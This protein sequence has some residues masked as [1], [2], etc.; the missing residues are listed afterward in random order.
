MVIRDPQDIWDF[1]SQISIPRLFGSAGHTKVRQLIKE[2]FQ[3]YQQSPQVVFE[4]QAFS[5][6]EGHMW[7]I[8]LYCFIVGFIILLPIWFY[9]HQMYWSGFLLT[10]TL[11]SS[12]IGLDRMFR[13]F[14]KHHIGEKKQVSG[15]NLWLRFE[16]TQPNAQKTLVIIAHYDSIS[17]RFPQITVVL[18]L[19]F[20]ELGGILFLL[21]NLIFS[22]LGILGW[23]APSAGNQFYWGIIVSISLWM[24]AFD[25]TTNR[26]S[27][28]LDNASG[29][30]ALD[31]LAQRLV[32]KPLETWRVLLLASD[33]EELGNR[34]AEAFAR[35]FTTRYPPEST[36]FL[37]VDTI[38][39]G[40]HNQDMI[41]VGSQRPKKQFS[42]YLEQIAHKI[43]QDN[44]TFPLR[45]I[46]FPPYIGI[47]TDHT[48]LIEAGYPC[49]II[50]SVSV[51]LHSSRDHIKNVKRAEYLHVLEYLDTF[52]RSL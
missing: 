6:L 18:T 3:R 11:I 44:S 31:F 1:F 43:L 38:G 24:I 21:H 40:Y 4:T 26:S 47:Q 16:P 28:A 50:G 51:V 42:L 39:V 25:N 29:V 7:I 35:E 20:G 19:I 30:V 9:Q 37:I 46:R 17:K 5:F 45:I 14:R 2:R 49:Q 23:I 32:S 34:G 27:G 48:P 12:L 36:Y 33:A 41:V 22:V 52:I 8:R 15:E 10:I 13:F